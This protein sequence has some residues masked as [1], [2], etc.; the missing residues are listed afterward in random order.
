M[1]AE[2]DVIKKKL[3]VIIDALI[4]VI[5]IRSVP[6][7]LVMQ[8]LEFIVN[9]DTD[10]LILYANQLCKENLLNVTLIV[11]RIKEIRN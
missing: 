1:D 8:R 9:A 3:H 10:S 2:S 5:P 11:G 4:I 6:Q 7:I